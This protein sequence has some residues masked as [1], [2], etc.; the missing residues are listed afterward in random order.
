LERLQFPE[1]AIHEIQPLAPLKYYKSTHHPA[2]EIRWQH[3]QVVTY[4]AAPR[5]VGRC[6]CVPRFLFDNRNTTSF[7]P[8]HQ[9]LESNLPPSLPRRP[10]PPQQ[11]RD[12]VYQQ[13]RKQRKRK[14]QR[15]RQYRREVE[16]KQAMATALT[17][18]AAP[19]ALA[20]CR[21][22]REGDGDPGT[23]GSA[24]AHV[25]SVSP[26]PTQELLP[27]PQTQPEDGL[28]EGGGDVGSGFPPVLGEQA[29]LE[30]AG[31]LSRWARRSNESRRRRRN[32]QRQAWLGRIAEL[33][34]Q[35]QHGAR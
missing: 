17:A 2:I 33:E 4:Y 29:V 21:L 28:L 32:Q 16:L 34:G 5:D 30:H 31:K 11:F 1:I 20:T 24:V 14:I 15:V 25:G 3:L 9:F 8:I 18:P 35:L 13:H 26:A 12:V 23:F 6:R 10:I 19:A 22:V 7:R 27:G